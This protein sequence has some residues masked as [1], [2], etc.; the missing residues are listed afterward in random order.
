[1]VPNGNVQV[2][3]F[4]CTDG[5]YLIE[6]CHRMFGFRMTVMRKTIIMQHTR[7]LWL[8]TTGT[9]M[10]PVIPNRGYSSGNFQSAVWVHFG[11][12][13]GYHQPVQVVLGTGWHRQLEGLHTASLPAVVAPL[14][15]W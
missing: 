9:T 3:V 13:T 6:T 8:P 4:P 5:K 2:M 12:G 11:C 15:K 7:Q 14:P 1:M 10:P